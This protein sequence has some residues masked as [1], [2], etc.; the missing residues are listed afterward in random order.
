MKKGVRAAVVSTADIYAQYQGQR[1]EC[2]RL[3]ISDAYNTWHSN[4]DAQYFL[5]ATDDD[6]TDPNTVPCWP[7]HMLSPSDTAYG[8][9]DD[10]KIYEVF[11]GRASVRNASHIEIYIDKVIDYETAPPFIRFCKNSITLRF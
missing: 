5:L 8:D 3:F 9:I 2:I 4:Y 6:P 11:P 1:H 7:S 10:D